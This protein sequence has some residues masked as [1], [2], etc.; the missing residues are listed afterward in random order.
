MTATAQTLTTPS[1]DSIASYYKRKI[2]A[3]FAT[4]EF[5]CSPQAEFVSWLQDNGIARTSTANV[6]VSN[7]AHN[8]TKTVPKKVIMALNGL[9]RNQVLAWRDDVR[10]AATRRLRKG[11]LR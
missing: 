1:D 4:P 2:A 9:T 8:K 6:Y 3:L 10:Q 7:L 5:G 11:C